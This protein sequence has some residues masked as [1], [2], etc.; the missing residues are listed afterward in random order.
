MYTSL[1]KG[2]EFFI[3]I[4]K[5]ILD[6]LG[7]IRVVIDRGMYFFRTSIS[8]FLISFPVPLRLRL[9]DKISLPCTNL[10]KWLE[11]RNE[12]YEEIMVKAWNKE[13]QY[14]EQT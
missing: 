12:F 10:L 13:G 14:F 5:F 4:F 6:H 9:A 2:L 7:N 1:K 11:E 3:L 8:L